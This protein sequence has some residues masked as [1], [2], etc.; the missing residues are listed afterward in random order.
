MEKYEK[1]LDYEEKKIRAIIQEITNRITDKV[2]SN[3]PKKRRR[4]K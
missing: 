1:N 3:F 2:V 4:K